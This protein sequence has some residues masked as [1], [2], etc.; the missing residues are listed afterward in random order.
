MLHN[1]LQDVVINC[2]E[3][4]H[5]NKVFIDR[6]LCDAA[7]SPGGS[8]DGGG[9]KRGRGLWTRGVLM[10]RGLPHFN[11]FAD[12]HILAQTP[13]NTY[14]FDNRRE[15]RVSGSIIEIGR[16]LAHKQTITI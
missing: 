14:L 8:W 9:D 11:S 1:N 6:F 15:R 13:K 12:L 3:I 2:A 7:S 4:Y 16:A 10:R 5:L